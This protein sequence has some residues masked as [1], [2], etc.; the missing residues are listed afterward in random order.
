MKVSVVVPVYNVVKYIDRCFD[1]ISSQSYSNNEIECIFVDDYG[2]DNSVELLH[3]RISNYSG[4]VDFRIIKHH[5]NRGLSGARNTGTEAATGEYIYYLD[6]DDEITP[7]CLGAL[8]EL[9]KKYRGVDIVQGNTTIFPEPKLDGNWRDIIESNFP[10]YSSDKLWIKE[11]C[12]ESPRIPVN[13]WNKLIRKEFLLK[14][15]LFFREGIIH[16]DEQWMFFVAKYISDIAF[17]KENCYVHYVVPDSIM[18][19][20]KSSYNSLKSALMIIKEM[21]ENIDN[22]LASVQKKHYYRY[23]NITIGRIGRI[24]RKEDKEV[25]SKSYIYFVKELLFSSIKRFS[26][27]E[28]LLNISLLIPNIRYAREISRWL[29]RYV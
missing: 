6:S 3:Q 4:E 9:A 2:P 18:Q 29:I 28:V 22:E 24:I 8:V 23:L 20:G 5:K 19:S 11:R 27:C 1:S 15:N 12:F 17:S 14:N 10:E 21:S 13:A 16:E 26:L 25:F 7:I